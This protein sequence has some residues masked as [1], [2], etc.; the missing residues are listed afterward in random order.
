MESQNEYEKLLRKYKGLLGVH[1]KVP[2]RDRSALSLVYTPGVGSSCKAIQNDHSKAYDLTNKKNAMLVL[3]DSSAVKQDNWNNMASLPFLEA[4]CLYYK[5]V[6][7]IDCYP[8]IID[9]NSIKNSKEFFETVV[10]VM[11]AYSLVEFFN[12]EEERVKEFADIKNFAHIGKGKKMDIK[13][14]LN[15][16]LIYA[17]IIRAAMDMQ[18]YC[19]LN[20]C[21]EYVLKQKDLENGKFCCTLLNIVKAAKEF[22]SKSDCRKNCDVVGRFKAFLQEG[23]QA[24]VEDYPN[25][26]LQH[27]RSKD[28]NS[29]LLH[30]RYKGVVEV[31]P[32]ISFKDPSTLD[33]LI[34][35]ENLDAVSKILKEKPELATELTFKSNF[36]AIITNGTAILG[37]GDIGALSGLPVM[38]GKSVLFKLFGGV[39]VMPLCIEEKD[40]KKFIELVR[41]ISPTFSVINLEDI[42]APDCFEIENTLIDLLPYPVFHDDQ[43][44][45]AIVVLAGIINSLRLAKKDIKDVKIIMNGAGAAGYSITELLLTQGAKNF[46]ICDTSG[47]I[48]TG[49][50]KNMNP[51]KEQLAS[52]T[53]CSKET[54]S[55]QEVIKGADVFI[56]VSAP[57]T[58]TGDMIKTMNDKP[59]IFALAN[60]TPEIMPEEALEAGAFIIAT[61]RSDYPNQ[62]NNS[63]AFPG[64]FRAALDTQSRKI[65]LDMKLAAGK[66][67][68]N[69]VKEDGLNP[70]Y[71]I[72]DALDSRVPVA[73]ANAVAEVALYNDKT[74]KSFTQEHVEDNIVGW[75]LEEKLKNWN[76]IER[77]NL[78]FTSDYKLKPKF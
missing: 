4:I 77:K 44:G 26:W 1:C 76:E 73:V 72:P 78:E 7:N 38:E 60:P 61:G 46:V 67:I 55:L 59:I 54:G 56:G 63:L 5:T 23:G 40:P 22:L 66:G 8:L 62:I 21:V 36:G 74:Q 24:W 41:R 64:I 51:Y 49:R 32:K 30:Y 12:V 34:T 6:A 20:P 19:D 39:D 37:F 75:L 45:T 65:S 18:C 43:H 28:E 68:A 70:A 69:L 13:S 17:G 52:L 10:A 11:P 14:S 50:P 2:V 3:T 9:L 58:L 29:L 53:N 42:K 27:K 15:I 48:Y 31:S 47:A 35:W 16:H 57:K 25:N 33:L 71:I